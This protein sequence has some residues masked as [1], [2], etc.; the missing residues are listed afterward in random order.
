VQS[1]FQVHRTKVDV[2]EPRPRVGV[3][4]CHCGVNIAATVDV[5]QVAKFAA[6][7]P[8]VVVARDYLYMCSDPGQGLIQQDIQELGLNRVVVASCS[9][10]MHE[11]TFR[12]AAQDV[13]LNPYRL[14]MSNIREQCSWVHRDRTAATDKAK[15]LVASG[16]AKAALLEPLQDREVGVTP[17]TVV[18]GGGVAGMAAALDVAEAG[19]PVYLVEQSDHLG[20]RLADLHR[21]FPTLESAPELLA[22]LE[23]RI[24]DHPNVTVLLS[25]QMTDVEGYVGNFEVTVS[26]SSLLGTSS[27]QAQA[28]PQQLSVGTIIIATGYDVFDA[29][30]KPELGYGQYPQVV[31]S[32]EMERRLAEGDL[33]VDGR[34]P[35]RVA[36]IQ[37]VGS[38][39][40]QIGNPYCSRV[41]CM[42]TA[43]QAALVQ[44]LLPEADVTVFY[45]DVRTFG[46]GA[47]EFWD[48]ARALGVRYRRGNVSEIYRGGDRV[49]LMGE[50]TLL[51][52]PI[53]FEADLVVLAVGMEP[54]AD[55]DALA[56]LLKLPRSADGFF[57]EL[58]PKLRPVDTAVDGVF[59]AGCCQGPKDIP[60][61]VAQAKAAASS[62][63]IPLIRGTVP[64]ESATA[65]VD[66]EQCAGCGMCVEV[67]PYGAPALDPLWGVSRINAVLC[68]GC[69]ACAVTCPSK[70][71]VLQH[72][73]PAQILAQ[74]DAL[75]GVGV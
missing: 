66:A 56:T 70:A 7:L 69:G 67:C 46:K 68:K 31:T 2:M 1:T 50:D 43:K 23:E 19:F 49:V 11:P 5:K 3:Y 75:V 63:L 36:F 14:E 20:G 33:A 22:E 18:I 4:V 32:L 48:E 10:C 54:R 12:A 17:G 13:G 28:E 71:I 26:G 35:K 16:V 37:C 65:L 58:H 24:R 41:C 74:V 61:T 45:M 8:D 30:R 42:Y 51:A 57:L 34:V 72:F 52:R 62:A 6:T 29:H 60:D 9:P 55:G 39:D 40:A 59:L 47:E 64:V 44:E 73:T 21:T 15:R 53:E 38:R 25:S 27:G